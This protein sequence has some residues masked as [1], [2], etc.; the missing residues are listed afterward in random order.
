PSDRWRTHDEI[1]GLPRIRERSDEIGVTVASRVCGQE[2][3]TR[4]AS[5]TEQDHWTAPVAHPVAVLLRGLEDLSHGARRV[6]RDDHAM[7]TDRDQ[8]L[9]AHAVGEVFRDVRA[10]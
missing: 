1:D 2:I 7:T 10:E 6:A 5:R 3:E 9:L 4:E 8:A